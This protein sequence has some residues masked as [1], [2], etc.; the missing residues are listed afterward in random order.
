VAWD[1]LK[2][3]LVDPTTVPAVVFTAPCLGQ[4]L[5]VPW[6]REPVL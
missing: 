1:A 6:R 5:N 2:L 3:T 4:T